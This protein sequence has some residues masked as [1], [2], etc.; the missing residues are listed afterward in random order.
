M[1]KTKKAR[2]EEAVTNRYVGKSHLAMV[3]R[4][5]LHLADSR[6]GMA[7]KFDGSH[8]ARHALEMHPGEEPKFGMTIVRTYKSSFS[9]AMGEVIRILYRSGERGVVLLNSKA[10]DFATYSLP[11]LSVMNWEEEQKAS[12]NNSSKSKKCQR[13]KSS[14][15]SDLSNKPKVKLKTPCLNVEAKTKRGK[16]SNRIGPGN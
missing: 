11:R 3:D 4:G 9:L 7:G 12:F 5:A 1:A 16:R 2:G 10:G 14:N 13:Y 15:S 6:R 8:M